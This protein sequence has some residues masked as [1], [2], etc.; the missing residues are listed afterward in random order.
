MRQKRVV[1]IQLRSPWI[2]AENTS[3]RE[4]KGQRDPSITCHLA[5]IIRMQIRRGT[6]DTAGKNLYEHESRDGH[7]SFQ[8][9]PGPIG[10][11]STPHVAA[12]S[13][14]L[15]FERS[16]EKFSFY[17]RL[18]VISYLIYVSRVLL[19]DVS[20]SVVKGKRERKCVRVCVRERKSSG[21]L[22]LCSNAPSA[23]L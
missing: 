5:E 17:L 18:V 2:A 11:I 19:S 16:F 4:R 1:R 15:D 7:P 22:C 8:V 20:V 23:R 9:N 3:G 10:E 6:D 13:R 12:V 21:I 14:D